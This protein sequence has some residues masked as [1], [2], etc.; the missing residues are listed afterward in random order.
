[1]TESDE[2]RLKG[3]L[4]WI[5]CPVNDNDQHLFAYPI[6]S[7]SLSLCLVESTRRIICHRA[8]YIHSS[9]MLFVY[10]IQLLRWQATVFCQNDLQ[11]EY[12]NRWIYWKWNTFLLI[13]YWSNK[14]SRKEACRSLIYEPRGHCR[15]LLSPIEL[16]FHIQQTKEKQRKC[17]SDERIRAEARGRIGEINDLV[18]LGRNPRG[19]RAR[20]RE[21][22]KV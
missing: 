14:T 1:M 19:K 3:W 5:P 21:K 4:V 9:E 13:F 18:W 20:E 16:V 12:V 6:F 10:R 22:I 8:R 2:W 11:R 7:L 15:W 17:D